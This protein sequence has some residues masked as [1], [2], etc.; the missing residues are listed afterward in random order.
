MLRRR[1][2]P[3]N[4]IEVKMSGKKPSPEQVTFLDRVNKTPHGIGLQAYSLV[5]VMKAAL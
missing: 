3:L 2:L 4:A 5:D 1:A